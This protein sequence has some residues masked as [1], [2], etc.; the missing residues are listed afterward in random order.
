VRFAR[1]AGLLL[2]SGTGLAN[3]VD[4]DSI[5]LGPPFIVTDA[6]IERIAGGLTAAIDAAVARSQAAG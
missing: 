6:E 2:Y 5:L 4:G 1:V 3:G